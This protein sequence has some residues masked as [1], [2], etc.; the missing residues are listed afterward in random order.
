M[1]GV[2]GV[3]FGLFAPSCFILFLF[4]SFFFFFPVRFLNLS[5][6]PQVSYC[7]LSVFRFLG[8]SG[9]RASTL[10]S[11]GAVTRI[12]CSVSSRSVLSRWCH[13]CGGMVWYGGGLV[14]IGPIGRRRFCI[15]H[16]PLLQCI[17]FIYRPIVLSHSRLAV[18]PSSLPLPSLFSRL[19]RLAR[20]AR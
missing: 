19:A 20:P 12:D 17:L 3:R 6:S 18:P 11:R 8:F 10:D 4:L 15:Q 16:G 2:P 1:M 14:F 9:F 7:L 5:R 13:W